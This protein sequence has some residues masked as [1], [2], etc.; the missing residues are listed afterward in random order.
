MWISTQIST[1]SKFWDHVEFQSAL[2]VGTRGHVNRI[3]NIKEFLYTVLWNS[4][5]IEFQSEPC[6]A[7]CIVTAIDFVRFLVAPTYDS[8]N[9]NRLFDYIWFAVEVLTIIPSGRSLTKLQFLP[10][11]VPGFCSMFNVMSVL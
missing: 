2:K 4:K 9:Y 5:H 1:Q 8:L 3:T 6:L 7:G 11:N 10:F